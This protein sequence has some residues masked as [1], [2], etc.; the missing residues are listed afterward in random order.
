MRSRILSAAAAVVAATCLYATSAA[1]R[2]GAETVPEQQLMLSISVPGSAN[3]GSAA[4]GGTLTAQ[5]G[6]V[7]V[8]DTRGGQARNW[9]VSVTSEGFTSGEHTIE[10]SAVRYWS[11]PATASNGAGPF[12][13]G[14][15]N[16]ASAVALNSRRTA[17]SRAGGIGN[18]A[19]SWVPSLW[20]E[21]P[22]TAAAGTY[23]GTVTH[24][25]L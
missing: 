17:F 12:N 24:S 4:P 10:S 21:I 15:P 11:G 22:E 6:T 9:T 7:R 8:A 16:A 20:I 13:P 2:E 3:L 18:N 25:V 5:L 23:T 14:Q 1:A 19:V